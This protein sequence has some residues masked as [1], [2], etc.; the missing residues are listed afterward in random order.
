MANSNKATANTKKKAQLSIAE[1]TA[2]F[3]KSGGKIQQIPT[4]VS[5][6]INQSGP[7]HIKLGN[8]NNQNQ[9]QNQ[10]QSQAKEE[11]SSS[12]ATSS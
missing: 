2:I 1:E 11:T 9:N 7:K 8:K 12:K 3:L 4:G 5:G 6:Q 10:S